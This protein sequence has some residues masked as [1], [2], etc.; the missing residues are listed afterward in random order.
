MDDTTLDGNAAAGAL[1]DVFTSEMTLAVTVCA[2][3]G[4]TRPL[5]EVRAYIAAPGLVLR[6]ASCGA[7][8]LRLVTTRGRAWLDLRGMQT[9]QLELVPS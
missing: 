6:C 3:C 8:L 1:A 4:A 2:S 9:L 5:A 7:V